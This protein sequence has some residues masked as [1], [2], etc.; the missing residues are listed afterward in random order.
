MKLTMVHDSTPVYWTLYDLLKERTP[1]QSISHK[2]MPTMVEHVDFIR[3]NP[4]PHWYLIEADKTPTK[5]VEFLGS[6]YLTK[7]RE[8]GIFIFKKHQGEGYA[9]EAIKEIIKM[10]PG[11]FLANVNPANEPSNKLFEKLGGKIIQHTYEVEL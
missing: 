4:Y 11:K 7:Q 3:S 8:I 1:E 10:H 6:V 5:P 9:T 2:K